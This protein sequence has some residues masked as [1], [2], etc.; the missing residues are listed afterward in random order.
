MPPSPI[1]SKSKRNA[2]HAQRAPPTTRTSSEG[3]SS[4]ADSSEFAA[5]SSDEEFE[6]ASPSTSIEYQPEELDEPISWQFKNGDPVWIKTEDGEWLQGTISGSN[7]RKGATRQ[8]EGLFF[9]VAYRHNSR[10][11]F[12]PLNGDL[13]PDNAETALELPDAGGRAEDLRAS[14]GKQA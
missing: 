11:Y 6:R 9:P 8:K 10:K 2:R 1:S 4:S 3:T 13:K 7:T 5:H 14:K 12:A